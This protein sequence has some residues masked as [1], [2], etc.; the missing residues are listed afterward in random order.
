MVEHLVRQNLRR[1]KLGGDHFG[2][3]LV[4]VLPRDVPS[5]RVVPGERAVAERAGHPDSLVS[6]SDVSSKVCFVTIGSLAER[7]FQFCS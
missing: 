7:A 3:D 2:V 4:P 5:H 6:L 1:P